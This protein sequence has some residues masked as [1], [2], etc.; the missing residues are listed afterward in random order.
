[1]P[2]RSATIELPEHAVDARRALLQWFD[3]H[4]RDMPWRDHPDPYAVWV[5][6]VMLQQTRVD[7]VR[8]YFRRWMVAFPTVEALAAAPLDDVLHAWQG[9]GYYSRAKNLHRAA[10]QV[11]ANGAF[12]S[13]AE[14]LRALPGIGPY[15]AGAIASIAFGEAAPLVDGNVM[16]VFTRWFGFDDDIA[17][18]ATQR[19]LWALAGQ[20]VNGPRPGDFNQALMEWGAT[21]C[22]PRAPRCEACPVAATCVSRL[23]G[24]IARRP[25][26]AKK[27][28]PRTEHRFA[29]LLTREDGALL[30]VRRPETGLLA[31]LW[32]PPL[33]PVWDAADWRGAWSASGLESSHE[34]HATLEVVRHVFSHIRLDVTPLVARYAA[35]A[36]PML[37]A[38][39][40]AEHAWVDARGWQALATSTLADKVRAVHHGGQQQL[41]PSS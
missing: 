28:A 31:G 32:E 13:T 15:T 19:Q 6:E 18:G 14:G 40:Y 35:S 29:F 2:A 16:R 20:W 34:P 10:K 8:D 23:E 26:K 1:M 37:R 12:P 25:V 3:A 17:R 9:L 5:S 27:R 38:L 7:T 39:P 24:A 41:L 4:R 21:V 22:T 33:S 30:V 11:V 36:S